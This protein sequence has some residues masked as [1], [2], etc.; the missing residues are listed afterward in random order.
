MVEFPPGTS[1][2]SI[3]DMLVERGVLAHR[4]P[5]LARYLIGRSHLRLK[6]GEY[7]FPTGHF[8]RLTSIAAWFRGCFSLH[9]GRSRGLRPIRYGTHFRGSSEDFPG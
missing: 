6:A 4:W 3:A 7:L 5:F 9:G 2:R 1:A 8:A